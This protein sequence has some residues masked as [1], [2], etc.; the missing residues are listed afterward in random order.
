MQK[1]V[2]IVVKMTDCRSCGCWRHA[3]LA[4]YFFTCL[5]FIT[6]ISCVRPGTE[7]FVHMYPYMVTWPW[8]ILNLEPSPSNSPGNGVP[9]SSS[10]KSLLEEKLSTAEPAEPTSFSDRE[11]RG[12]VLMF[13][14]E[15]MVRGKN[16]DPATHTCT[17]TKTE[18]TFSLA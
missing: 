17:H 6:D 11:L 3:F 7:M 18:K 8:R 10:D 2:C 4:L 15:H 14:E 9:C 1:G 13:R 12:N 16:I 5:Y